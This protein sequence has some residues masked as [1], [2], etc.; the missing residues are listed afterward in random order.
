M[1][2]TAR[3]LHC[4]C[5][6]RW[7]SEWLWPQGGCCRVHKSCWAATQHSEVCQVATTHLNAC[8][9]KLYNV[10]VS[11]RLQYSNFLQG[12]AP[13]MSW[14]MPQTHVGCARQRCLSACSFT[15]CTEPCLQAP[16]Q[17]GQKPAS[18]VGSSSSKAC[19]AQCAAPVSKR[20][21]SRAHTSP[22]HKVG[23]SQ[24]SAAQQ[25]STQMAPLQEQQLLAKQLSAAKPTN[26]LIAWASSCQPSTP[27]P[28]T[29]LL[30]Q[31]LS[32]LHLCS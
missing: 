11:A 27:Q 13:S 20:D 2:S 5:S 19:K 28:S 4:T 6:R 9:H 23:R 7:Q 22:S 21:L 15:H 17:E 8:P 1:T 32:L 10:A 18:K 14:S 26:G 3:L 12:Q 16:L 31:Q 29:H 24:K 25:Q 30:D